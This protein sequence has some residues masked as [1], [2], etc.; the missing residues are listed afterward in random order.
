MQT[1]L[2]IKNTR[3]VNIG[4][5]KTLCVLLGMIVCLIGYVTE[6]VLSLGSVKASC[7]TSSAKKE[8][9]KDTAIASLCAFAVAISVAAV[10]YV[11]MLF[12]VGQGYRDGIGLEFIVSSLVY[13]AVY[14]TV[15]FFTLVD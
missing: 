12:L 8:K 7:R 9:D 15:S 1:A 4:K 6:R 13:I 10:V 14:K 5:E 11:T 2:N 3:N